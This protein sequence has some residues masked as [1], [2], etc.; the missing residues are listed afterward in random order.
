MTGEETVWEYATLSSVT[1]K[2]LDEYFSSSNA[3]PNIDKQDVTIVESSRQDVKTLTVHCYKSPWRHI[4]ASIDYAAFDALRPRCPY[5][6][7]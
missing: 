4:D 1:D 7:G 6:Q 3:E 2:V 5:F